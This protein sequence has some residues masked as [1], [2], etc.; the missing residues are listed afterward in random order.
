[1]IIRKTKIE[2]VY[3]INLEPRKDGRG[4]FTRVFAKEELEKNGIKYDIVHINRSLTEKKG[5]I[6]GFHFQKSPKEENKIV[7]CLQGS[8]FDVA[9]DLR[10]SSK[11]YGK[12][13]GAVLDAKNKAMLMIPKGC[14]HAF[15]TLEKNTVV[16][17]FVSQYYSPVHERG[18]R[19]DDPAFKVKWPV[20]KIIV[21]EKDG[22]WVHVKKL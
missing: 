3:L 10:K 11:T 15:Q 19:W 13:F 12:W 6:R 21:S 16:E 22:L 18:I 20:K 8:I 1:M 2:G 14:A 4:Y 9:L 5:T 7:Q 17:Y